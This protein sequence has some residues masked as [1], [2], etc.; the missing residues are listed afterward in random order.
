[1]MVPG[2]IH[3]NDRGRANSPATP[4]FRSVPV[5]RRRSRSQ[6][7]ISHDQPNL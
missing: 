3:G 7:F 4:G 5:V 2:V 1:M 6:E